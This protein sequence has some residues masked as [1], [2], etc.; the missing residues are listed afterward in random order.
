MLMRRA[1]NRQGV[2]MDRDL[3]AVDLEPAHRALAAGDYG[4]A[5]DTLERAA[6]SERIQKRRAQFDLHLAACYALYGHEGL[7]GGL[8]ALKN[9]VST[10]P[11]LVTDALYQALYWEFDAYRGAPVTEVKRGLRAL[12]GDLPAMAAY[13]V[14]AALLT[15]GSVKGAQRRLEAMSDSDLPAYLVWRRW[16]LLGQ[17]HEAQGSWAQAAIAYAEAVHGAPET[18]RPPERLAYAG[19]LIELARHQEALAVLHDIDEA[20][21][22]DADRALLRYV[23]GRA[24]LDAGN[25]NRALELLIDARQ[26]DVDPDARFSLAFATGQALMALQRF[27]EAVEQLNLAVSIAP[28]DHRAFAQHEA[29]I[30]NLEAE[31]PE[32][33]LGLLE[34]VLSDPRYPHRAE[35]LADLAE[36]RWR[37]GDV[38][39]ARASAEQALELGAVGPACLV[40]GAIAFDYFHLDEAVTWYEQALAA[41]ATGEPTWVSA[42]QMLCDV[43]AQRG[44]AAAERVLRHAATVL[45]YTD[46]NSEWRRPLEAHIEHARTLLGGHDRVLN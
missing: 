17:A 11:S 39:N 43:H 8:G 21:L 26:F 16:S 40:L 18:E 12:S 38:E 42:H 34:D 31:A 14:A 15:I 19:C 45:P 36:V 30:A 20:T 27:P 23:E 24:Q 46:I 9:A 7:E 22:I 29:A 41:S 6:R 35:A 3:A 5:L 13:H 1:T 44:V 2:G 28:A 4:A 33:A 32:T 25:P 37:T 10:D